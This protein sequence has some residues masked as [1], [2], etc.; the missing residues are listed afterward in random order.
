MG[1]EGGNAMT[2]GPLSLAA[3]SGLMGAA[4]VA[5]AAVA[6]HRLESPTL[7]TA[8]NMLM[9]HA[10]AGLGLAALAAQS[11]SGGLA[12]AGFVL[13]TAVAL[14]AGAVTYHAVNGNHIFP[15]AAPIGGSLTIATWA[16]IGLICGFKILRR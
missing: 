5:L 6:A 16:A 1:T 4:G 3:I 11:R 13:I 10:A 2:A 8:S 12:L 7:V 15:G 9:I 14:F